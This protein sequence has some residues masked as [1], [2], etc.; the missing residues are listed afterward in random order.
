M[1]SG[2]YFGRNYYLRIHNSIDALTSTYSGIFAYAAIKQIR[3]PI[4]FQEF[5]AIFPK[6]HEIT[7]GERVGLLT[8]IP[9][10]IDPSIVWTGT[11][12][13]NDAPPQSHWIHWSRHLMW[14]SSMRFKIEDA[15]GGRF[16]LHYIGHSKFGNNVTRSNESTQWL[17]L[18]TGAATIFSVTQV[19]AESVEEHPAMPRQATEEEL[20]QLSA[21]PVPAPE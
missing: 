15:G 9:E 11:L 17:R 2:I 21:E 4:W 14:M 8:Y 6:K 3:H 10:L 7:W 18:T 16:T 12:S 19:T 5:D 13:V 20:A 1:G